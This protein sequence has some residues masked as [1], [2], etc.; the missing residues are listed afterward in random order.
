M[1]AS[2]LVALE[3]RSSQYSENDQTKLGFHL[4]TGMFNLIVKDPNREPPERAFWIGTYDFMPRPRTCCAY[5][6]LPNLQKLEPPVNLYLPCP[7]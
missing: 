5:A 1:A 2:G 3:T 7:H 4:T 6:H